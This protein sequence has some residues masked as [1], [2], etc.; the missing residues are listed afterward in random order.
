MGNASVTPWTLPAEQYGRFL[1]QVFDEWVRKDVGQ[2]F[3]Q[4]FDMALGAWMGQEPSLCVFAETCG[5]ALI[6][7]H[8]GDLYSCDHFVYPEHN[9]GNV[10]DTSIAEM[11]QS[12]H[13]IKFGQ[14]KK[15]TLP[16]QW[17]VLAFGDTA[18]QSAHYI[19]SYEGHLLCCRRG[20]G[21]A[22]MPSVTV[23]PLVE[24][25]ELVEVVPGIRIKTPLF[26]QS[27]SQSSRILTRLS[28][29]VSEVA[30][31][32]LT[33]DQSSHQISP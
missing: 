12:D 29:V 3:V 6:V 20:I 11:V 19:P 31:L 15:D 1:N 16:Q 23:R 9:L 8:N 10:H 21:W 7:E 26:W 30:G 5:D 14:D 2:I 17:M 13:Q 33:S 28:E 24:S 4:I 25:G 18:R 27:R 32:W 22:M